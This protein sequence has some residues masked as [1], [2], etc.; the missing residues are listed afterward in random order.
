MY[1]FCKNVYETDGDLNFEFS[2]GSQHCSTWI[3]KY[4]MTNW[5]I[6]LIPMA[7]STVNYISKLILRLA[8]IYERH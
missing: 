6:Y 4:L 8:S 5:L 1:C 3:S 2:D 7:I